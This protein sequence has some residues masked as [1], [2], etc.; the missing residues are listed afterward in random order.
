[1]PTAVYQPEICG[2][3]VDLRGVSVEQGA[4]ISLSIQEICEVQSGKK[5]LGSW[6]CF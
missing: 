6:P 2:L 3:H 5:C 1:M 4:K